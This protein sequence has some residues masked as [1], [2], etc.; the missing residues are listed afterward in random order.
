MATA[1]K[2]SVDQTATLPNRVALD[3]RAFQITE[4]QFLQ[5]C[6]D[7]R[8]LRLELTV[9]K[10]LIIMPPAGGTTSWRNSNLNADLVIWARRD[11]TGITFDSNAGF[12]LPNGAV[13]SPDASWVLLSRWDALTSEEQDK[14]APICP[15]FVI[16]LRSP[17]DR[18]PDLQDKMTEY[19]E[20]GVRLGFLLDPQQRRVYV[21]RP[22]ESVEILEEPAAVSGDPVLPGFV[23]D[24]TTIWQAPTQPGSS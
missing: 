24:L 1:Q 10:E 19:L 3:I 21:Y 12:T 14:F 20:S 13:R 16:E 6:S 17:S 15:D 18:L 5:L 22:G 11:G 8:D 4:D 7:N 9:N 23:L 2:S